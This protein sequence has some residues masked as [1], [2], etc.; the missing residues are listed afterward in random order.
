MYRGR[1]ALPGVVRP[2]KR[3]LSS[4]LETS[5]AGLFFREV[6]PDEAQGASVVFAAAAWIVS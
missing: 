5:I 4:I 3:Y 1:V 2:T 6:K